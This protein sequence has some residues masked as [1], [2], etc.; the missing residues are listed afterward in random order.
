MCVRAV[1]SVCEFFRFF[2]CVQVFRF[3]TLVSL[4]LSSMTRDQCTAAGVSN[5]RQELAGGLTVDGVLA[6]PQE[7][8]A[9]LIKPVGFYQRK[10][11]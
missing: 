2:L 7:T 1:Y 10:A 5:L 9:K 8:I 6:T 11:G 4:M 3:Q